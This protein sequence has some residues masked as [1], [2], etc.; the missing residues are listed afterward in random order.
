MT[1]RKTCLLLLLVTACLSGAVFY[2]SSTYDKTNQ[3]EVEVDLSVFNDL[4]KIADQ[5]PTFIANI[6]ELT[7]MKQSLKDIAL[8]IKYS[9]LSEK[10]K[11][12]IRIWRTSTIVAI[13]DVLNTLS[14]LSVKTPHAIQRFITLNTRLL[15]NNTTEFNPALYELYQTLQ[16]LDSLSRVVSLRYDLI[17]T[18]IND[19][20]N[21]CKDVMQ[22]AS[23]SLIIW[24][25]DRMFGQNMDKRLYL[26]DLEMFQKF[27][28]AHRDRQKIMDKSRTTIRTHLTAVEQMIHTIRNSLIRVPKVEYMETLKR[29]SEKLRDLYERFVSDSRYITI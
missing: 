7:W 11:D 9:E 16:K 20:G 26:S 12:D 4:A 17:N 22:S 1:T 25:W 8:R 29:T 14:V 2:I 13:D 21:I 5:F 10:C 23:Q 15:H 28:A 24:I 27:I 6:N 18:L 19:H 3:T